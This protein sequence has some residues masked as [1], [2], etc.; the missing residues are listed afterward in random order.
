MFEEFDAKYKDFC[1]YEITN[2]QTKNNLEKQAKQEIWPSSPLY[3]IVDKL[4]AVAKSERQDDVLFFDGSKY[5]VIHLAW[6]KGNSSGPRYKEL[7]PDELS[8]YLEWY[9]LN[10]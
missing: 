8:G 7:L 10:V 1:W 6:N 4:E 9:Y 3:A 2:E 5:Y